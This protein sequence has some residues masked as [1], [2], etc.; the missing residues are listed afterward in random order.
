MISE[1]GSSTMK[2]AKVVHSPQS[3]LRSGKIREISE[4]QPNLSRT[5]TER[6]ERFETLERKMEAIMAAISELKA[7]RSRDSS[8]KSIISEEVR[9][10]TKTKRATRETGYS[11]DETNAREANM[12]IANIGGMRFSRGGWIKN[13]FDELKFVGRNDKIN[14][15]RFLK[16]FN[17][18]A[19][20]ERVDEIEQLYFFGKCLKDQAAMWFEIRDFACIYDAKNEFVKHFWGENQQAK[21]REDI[22]RKI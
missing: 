4:S 2:T 17:E 15:I 10:V 19:K 22:P 18:I 9:N 21:F 6:D 8:P 12:Q 11:S 5:R 7:R 16:R 1:A 20:Y 14:P 3:I 13:P